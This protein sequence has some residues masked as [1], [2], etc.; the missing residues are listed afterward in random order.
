ME[1][2]TDFFQDVRYAVRTLGRAPTFTAAAILTLA[3]AI[4]A[5]S[6]IFSVV[7]TVL[8][9]PAP[10][11]H[12]DRLVV[13]GYT[14]D[15]RW[16]PRMSPSK[17]NLWKERTRVFDDISAARFGSADLSDGAETQQI[18]AGHVGAEFFSLLGAPLVKGRT[19]TAAEDRP[20]G[21]PVAVLSYG[22]WQR[23]LGSDGHAVGTVLMIDR[24]RVVVVGIL[25]S[26]FDTTIF[27]VSPD[28]WIPIR[29][30]RQRA[31][32]PPSLWAAG[33]L[34]PGVSLTAANADARLVGDAFRR[35]FPEAA[36]PQDTFA[37]A[38]LLD[39]MVHDVRRSLF[40]FMGAVAVVLLIACTNVA[41]LML[42]RASRRQREIAVRVAIGASRGR[43]ARWLL[44]E[45]LVLSTAGG[46]LGLALAGMSIRTLL[47]LNPTEIPRIGPHGAGVGLDWRVLSFTFLVSVL[48][49]LLF[50]AWPAR[51]ASRTE[52]SVT[53]TPGDRRSSS[54]LRLRSARALL[55]TSELALS[56]MLLVAAAL[57]MRTF[58]A[59]RVVDRG[60]ESHDVLTMRM[61]LSDSRFATTAAV[62]RLV[63]E[64]SARVEA[65][66]GIVAV[67]AAVSLPLESDWLTSFQIVGRPLLTASPTLVRER[68][69]SP[70]YFGVFGIQ[71][72]AGR[73]FSD[74]DHEGTLPVAL[75]NQTMARRFWPG[76]DHFKD[77]VVLFPGF[78]LADDPP[79]LIVG[80]ISDVRDGAPLNQEVQPTVYVPMAQVP[81]RLLH[82]EPMAWVIRLRPGTAAAGPTISRELRISSGGVAPTNNRSMDAITAASTAGT[83]FAMLLM[84]TFGGASVLLAAI[85]VFGVMA[86]SVQQRAREF[87]IRLALG[88]QPKNV[89]NLV[90]AD[91]MRIAMC[92]TIIG[93]AGAFGLSQLLNGF[94]FGVTQHD[95]VVLVATPL[96][97]V[98]VALTAMWVP[99]RRAS[100]VDPATALRS[101]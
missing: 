10:Y 30:D 92:G 27:G 44:T 12:A 23:H 87:G 9:R 98:S 84:A 14:F 25:D 31:S 35:A 93:L 90:L 8:L 91:G 26:S 89:R 70:G 60:F 63:R 77:Q 58:I 21:D 88:A 28:V 95:P 96:V 20:G 46:A 5:N 86:Y 38:P 49:G 40:A 24:T 69:V 13:L 18:L 100:R 43:I 55:L 15:G 4:G 47:T 94:L 56:L 50:G 32:H 85:G 51:R 78:V 65:L 59:L 76:G 64:G 73:V 99:S 97:L 37:V 52:L 101:E 22:F 7:N 1:W 61:P 33:R 66:P 6:A 42:V 29:L 54:G 45:S 34:R 57:L 71:P 36:G 17:F 16:V 80:V 83:S 79:R 75:V 2:L 11:P 72:V 82:T 53:F 3:L 19:F 81:A 68:I 74:D 48:T 67:G 41:N 39:V 62:E